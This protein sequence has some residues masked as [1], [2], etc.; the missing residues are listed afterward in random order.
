MTADGGR[1]R[2]K[3]SPGRVGCRT[4]DGKYGC[5]TPESP[6][7]DEL[8]PPGRANNEVGGGDSESG[9]AQFGHGCQVIQ[10]NL[11]WVS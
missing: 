5:G 2:A 9:T 4:S 6:R 8:K 3:T 7:R 1:V 11:L 10:E